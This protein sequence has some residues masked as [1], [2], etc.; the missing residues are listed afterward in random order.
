[1]KKFFGM[2]VVAVGFSS[3]LFAQYGSTQNYSQSNGS[4]QSQHPQGQQQQQGI[5]SDC[6]HLSQQEQQFASKLSVM[7]RTMF[8]RHFSTPQRIEVMTL[9][10]AKATGLQGQET[11]ISPDEAV[12]I[13]MKNSRTNDSSNGS[14]D[15][16]QQ[17]Y[18][19]SQQQ[20]QPGGDYSYPSGSSSSS[21]PYSN[22]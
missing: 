13:V 14:S 3:M 22:Y 20:K 8:C 12:E 16:Q 9:S 21:N 19:Y 5:T 10:N 17:Q 4:Q 6:D 1:M 2:A 18:P 7:H 15:T 11:S